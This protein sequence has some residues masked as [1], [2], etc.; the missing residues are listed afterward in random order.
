MSNQNKI[1]TTTA[2]GYIFGSYWIR[3][4][5]TF[6]IAMIVYKGGM[7]LLGVHL[8]YFSGLDSFNFPWL[9][10]MSILPVAV[11]IL[12]G[13][14][15]GF[16]GKYLA[17]FPPAAV[18]IWDYQHAATVDLP[19]YVHLLPWGMWVM[20]VIL[21]MEFCAVGGFIGEILIRKRRAWDNGIVSVADSEPLPEDD[22]EIGGGPQT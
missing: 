2:T 13:M 15:Y 3:A 8:E 18:M 17:H 4:L 12:I 22:A 19:A 16:G 5:V 7:L 21:Q 1:N 14:I 9:V 6:V 10:A 11:G 20:F